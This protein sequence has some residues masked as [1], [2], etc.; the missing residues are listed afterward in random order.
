[1]HAW[2]FFLYNWL[3]KTIFYSLPFSWM[4]VLLL[5]FVEDKWDNITEIEATGFMLAKE[6]SSSLDPENTKICKKEQ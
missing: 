6:S 4:G 1:M 5:H 3:S 2:F